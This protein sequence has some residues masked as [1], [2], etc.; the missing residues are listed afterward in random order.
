M[1]PKKIHYCWFGGAE[2]HDLAKHCIAS[3][4]KIHPDFDVVEWNE[5]NSPL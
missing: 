5:D 2:K 1:I 3:W 4:K